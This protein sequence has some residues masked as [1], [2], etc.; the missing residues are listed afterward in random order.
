VELTP[1]AVRPGR[2]AWRFLLPAVAAALGTLV[3]AV[4][5]LVVTLD[6]DQIASVVG[7]LSA[8]PA[9]PARAAVDRGPA[10]DAACAELGSRS[11]C[12]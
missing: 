8:T 5:W 12:A 10:L 7:R 3:T 2:L 1:H 4:P 9:R 11:R 6:Q